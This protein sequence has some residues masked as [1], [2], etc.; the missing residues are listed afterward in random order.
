MDSPSSLTSATTRPAPRIN[1]FTLDRAVR[2]SQEGCVTT[3]MTIVSKQPVNGYPRYSKNRTCICG[4]HRQL[5]VVVNQK[6]LSS[7][8]PGEPNESRFEVLSGLSG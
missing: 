5:G 1:S 2:Y 7:N 8:A 4:K 3:G 6:V